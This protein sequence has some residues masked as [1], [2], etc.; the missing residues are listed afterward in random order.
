LIR[1]PDPFQTRVAKL[2]LLAAREHG[3][4]LGGGHAL[5][6]YGIV[7]RPTEDVDLFTDADDGVQPAAELVKRALVDAGMTIQVIPET[8]EL[9][10]LFFR[11]AELS[12]DL[13]RV[14]ADEWRRGAVRRALAAESPKPRASAGSSSTMPSA[15]S[16]ETSRGPI[17]S[18]TPSWFSPAIAQKK[19]GGFSMYHFW[20]SRGTSQSPPSCIASATSA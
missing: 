18:G 11:V 13:R 12:E 2:A 8:S 7:S 9:G 16:V 17:A 19:T 14:L 1:T 20:W 4:A 15:A 5:I 3:F 6:A 10:D